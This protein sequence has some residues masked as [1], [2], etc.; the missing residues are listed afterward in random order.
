MPAVAPLAVGAKS[1]WSGG[2]GAVPGR[3][4]RAMTQGTNQTSLFAFGISAGRRGRGDSGATP[5]LQSCSSR[6][7][8][9]FWEW[10][11]EQC[12]GFASRKG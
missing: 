4:Q 12:Q 7:C 3:G 11:C 6:G 2:V 8:L 9:L 1:C 10:P 5:A